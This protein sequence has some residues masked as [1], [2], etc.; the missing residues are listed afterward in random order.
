V[1]DQEPQTL[2]TAQATLPRFNE[3]VGLL[4]QAGGYPESVGVNLQQ[5][6]DN[7]QTYIEIQ[8]AIIKRGR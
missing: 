8:D 6:L 5:L 7:A 2:G 4:Q 1:K 3:A